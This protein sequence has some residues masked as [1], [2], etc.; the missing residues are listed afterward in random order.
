M[1][2]LQRQKLHPEVP[3]RVTRMR[4]IGQDWVAEAVE[5]LR[6]VDLADVVDDVGD[7]RMRDF[8]DT[9]IRNADPYDPFFPP[10][11]KIDSIYSNRI[12]ADNLAIP[13]ILQSPFGRSLQIAPSSHQHQRHIQ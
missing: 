10:H 7:R 13:P 12:T 6:Q 3:V 8:F 1:Q 11:S 9:V 5:L 2:L 4:I